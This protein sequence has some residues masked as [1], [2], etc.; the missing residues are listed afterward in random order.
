[1]AALRAPIV[2]MMRDAFI[3]EDGGEVVGGAAVFPW[4]GARRDVDI[5]GG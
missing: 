1:M 3:R 2:E 5:A 4:A